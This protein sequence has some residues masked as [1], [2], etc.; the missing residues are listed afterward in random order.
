MHPTGSQAI[1]YKIKCRPVDFQVAEELSV[2]VLSS[3]KHRL[4]RL[5]KSGWNTTDALHSICTRKKI[6]RDSFAYAGKKDRHALTDQYV[7]SARPEDLSIVLKDFKLASVG[8]LDR[9]VGPDLIHCN[10]FNIVIRNL[11]SDAPELV[12]S[13]L[14]QVEITGIP[15]YFDDQRFGSYDTREGHALHKLLVAGPEQFAYLLLT[16]IQ[17]A[18]APRERKRKLAIREAW[19]DMDAC[20]ALG[21][22]GKFKRFFDYMRRNPENWSAALEFLPTEELGMSI[23]AYQSHLWNQFLRRFYGEIAD[24][25]AFAPGLAGDYFFYNVRVDRAPER[26]VVEHSAGSAG[27]AGALPDLT[28]ELPGQKLQVG[29]YAQHTEKF[30]NKYKDMIENCWREIFHEEQIDSE[31]LSRPFPGGRSMDSFIRRTLFRPMDIEVTVATDEMYPRRKKINLSFRL[32]R[33][34]YATMLIK[35]ITSRSM[36]NANH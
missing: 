28:L 36:R 30:R 21:A 1:A 35:A 27:S 29:E 16:C 33:G 12:L 17:P 25:T 6:P 19:P 15:T 31:S 18:I 7:S 26:G 24:A 20:A 34:M 13:R 23:S 11:R 8:F 9:P 4:Y 14:K 3:G 32:D 22:D 5:Q 10:R 2:D